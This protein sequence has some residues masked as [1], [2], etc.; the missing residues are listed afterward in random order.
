MRSV[1]FSLQD[2]E[3]DSNNIRNSVLRQ[4]ATSW[5]SIKARLQSVS[6]QIMTPNPVDS[7]FIVV[8]PL[9]NKKRQSVEVATQRIFL[10]KLFTL[11]A[12]VCECAGD[13]M[14]DRFQ[15]DVWTILAR[16]FG[17][18]HQRR[19]EH[20]Q[21][22]ETEQRKRLQNNEQGGLIVSIGRDTE[23]RKIPNGLI[24]EELGVS[25]A[26]RGVVKMDF[27]ERQQNNN[28]STSGTVNSN[29]FAEQTGRRT[30]RR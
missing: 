30:E 7:L 19:Q 16:H 11:V 27:S 22:E 2:P 9:P 21:R 6:D 23:H 15:N 14:A 29:N 28:K 8:S 26:S 13:F 20:Q 25:G 10:A 1:I 4:A 24:T 17:E 18:L 5:P 12:T 3:D